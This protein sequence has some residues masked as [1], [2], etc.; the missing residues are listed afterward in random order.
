MK[1]GYTMDSGVPGARICARRPCERSSP[2]RSN[3]R[4]RD[5]AGLRQ[6]REPAVDPRGGEGRP[7][8][9]GAVRAHVR[10]RDLAGRALRD[11]APLTGCPSVVAAQARSRRSVARRE[12]PFSACLI[13]SR[14]WAAATPRRRACARPPRA[15]GACPRARERSRRRPGAFRARRAAA[16]RSRRGRATSCRSS[17]SSARV[18]AS[19][20]RRAGRA[21][22]LAG[23]RRCRCLV[24]PRRRLRG[25]ES[26]HVAEPRARGR[27]P[28]EGA[29][30]EL[31]AGVGID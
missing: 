19:R 3:A 17:V 2:T 6:R 26:E 9:R 28:L 1:I 10:G 25:R 31:A 16:S 24:G 13:S 27:R 8:P 14:A 12:R 21:R 22:G 7:Q 30:G 18:G 5:R 15:A 11:R 4:R 20:L 29:G 23:D